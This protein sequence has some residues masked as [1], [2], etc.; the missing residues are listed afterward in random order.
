[1][2]RLS[3]RRLW[4]QPRCGSGSIRGR[5]QT[6]A[7]LTAKAAPAF[8]QEKAKLTYWGGLIFSEGEQSLVR[9]NQPVG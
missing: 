5:H 8:L 1:M 4:Q 9:H 6:D 3:R 2:T 7:I